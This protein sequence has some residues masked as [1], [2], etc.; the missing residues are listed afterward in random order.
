MSTTLDSFSTVATTF[1]TGASNTRSQT[2]FVTEP[3]RSH[4]LGA[5]VHRDGVNFAVFSEFATSVEL[6]LFDSHDD[7][8]PVQVIS[9]NPDNNKT[10]HIWH[11]FV[12][13]LRPGMHYA[14]RIDGP[15]DRN[16]G[17]R[18]DGEKLLIDPY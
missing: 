9:L 7:P 8:Q 4:P 16:Q 10:F 2:P 11:V 17:H 6:L 5:T 12:R 15:R 14:Y 1:V 13:G 3:G 18:F